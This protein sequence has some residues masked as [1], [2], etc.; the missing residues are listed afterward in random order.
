MKERILYAP[1]LRGVEL[2]RTLAKYG[3]NSF[4]L[5]IMGDSELSE[6]ALM[7]SGYIQEKGFVDD[8][9]QANILYGGIQSIPYFKEAT[10][11]DAKNVAMALS[12][13]R[14]F[15]VDEEEE[16]VEALLADGEFEEKN[17][18][19]LT[20]YNRYIARIEEVNGI[21]TI[22]LMRL[23]L[24]KASAIE[25]KEWL[26]L[27]EYPLLPLQEELLKKLSNNQYTSC[28]MLDL[29]HTQRKELK[30]QHFIEGYGAENEIRA[31]FETIVKENLPLDE[32]LIA[33]TD[34]KQYAQ[35]LFELAQEYKI[36]LYFG[37]G[38]S[39]HNSFPIQFLSY[40]IDWD[41]LGYHGVDALKEVVQGPFF[42]Q[43]KLKEILGEEE[44]IKDLKYILSMAGKLKLSFDSEKNNKRIQ[45]YRKSLEERLV[46]AKKEGMKNAKEIERNLYTLGLVERFVKELNQGVVYFMQTYCR[47]RKEGSVA[48]LDQR[49]LAIMTTILARYPEDVN[50]GYLG[51]V[52][53]EIAPRSGAVAMSDGGYLH[54]SDIADAKAVMRKHLFVVGLSA[55]L[56]PGSPKEN[57]VLLDNDWEKVN[58]PLA[59]TSN[60]SIVRKRKE[61]FALLTL[62]NAL[63]TEISLSYSGYDLAA[64]KNQNASSV[65]VDIVEEL[66]E[67][68]DLESYIEKVGFFKQK[69]AYMDHLGKAYLEGKQYKVEAIRPDPKDVAEKIESS[70]DVIWS[71]SALDV[72]F[73]CSMRFL[74]ENL[75][76]YKK[77]DEDRPLVIIPANDL[78]TLVHHNMEYLGSHID[79]GKDEFLAY[80]D[81]NFEEYL[82]S[83]IPLG[84][85]QKEKQ[86]YMDICE[87]LWEYKPNE[88]Y[89]Y[90][91]EYLASTH[92]NGLK[93]GGYPD[94]IEKDEESGNYIV[95]DIKTGRSIKHKENDTRTCLQTMIY[96]WL[97]EDR[98]KDKKVERGEYR[99]AR[100]GR[101]ISC[102]YDEKHKSELGEYLNT[103]KKT[104][105]EK[106]FP[107][108]KYNEKDCRYC[109]FA[110]YCQEL[111]LRTRKEEA[112]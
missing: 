64:L 2:L 83:R 23:A 70:D 35:I 74:L 76:S 40:L 5:R 81:H 51:E 33:C 66:N 25:G 15:I 82:L 49:A 63:D 71:P 4:G 11:E 54:I 77:E 42:D 6:Y 68:K 28:S 106:V 10:Y 32:V 3:I 97:F 26:V 34:T 18:A 73:D 30:I 79:M 111:Q 89:I 85:I 21:D 13:L 69:Y 65:L 109:S 98:E 94:A 44:P 38:I 46:F 8:M 75:L 55:N 78:G 110:P 86:A 48:A 36:P 53:R 80:C 19:I 84:D 100:V 16:G 1:G 107:F 96:A 102:I 92:M 99:Y 62:A 105:D 43:Q 27:E 9:G 7:H 108:K 29:F 101:T 50:K 39:F 47:L 58:H 104:L 31:I 20:L 17:E 60:Y 12:E 88:P 93:I 57:Y 56:Y 22:G 37:C 95:A 90:S 112:E 14:K 45:A 24:E 59:P 103:F 41:T 72:Y 87:N 52:I 61:F 67:G 91:E